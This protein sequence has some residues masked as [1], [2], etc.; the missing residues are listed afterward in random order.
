MDQWSKTTSHQKRDSDNLQYGKLRSYRGS[1]LV[2][3]FFLQFS[4]KI[5]DILKTGDLSPTSSSSSSTSPTTTVLS[6]SET[7]EREDLS[8]IDSH[9]V[10]V[11]SSYVEEMTERRDPLLPKLTKNPKPNKDETTIERRDPC[12]S[13]TLEWLQEF[14]EES[15]GWSPRLREVRICV[16]TMFVLTSLKTE[17]ARSARWPIL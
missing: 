16:N 3:E 5:N 2:I 6:D 11:S 15:C 9:P 12:H 1:R 4:N 17:I 7:Q 13:E 10:L 14:R 8:G